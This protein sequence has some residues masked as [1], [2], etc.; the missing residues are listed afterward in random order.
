MDS[1]DENILPDE[2]RDLEDRLARRA[3]PEADAGFRARVLAAVARELETRPRFRWWAA[4]AAAACLAVAAIVLLRPTDPQPPLATERTH[5]VRSGPSPTFM[6]YRKALAQSPEQ[7][8]E[9]LTYHGYAL[10]RRGDDEMGM[11]PRW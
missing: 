9:L 4:A 10:L 6:A 5:T 2:L 8:D 11:R 1:P 7:L 3:A